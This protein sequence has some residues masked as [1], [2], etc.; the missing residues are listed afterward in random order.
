LKRATPRDQK[1]A[2]DRGQACTEQTVQPYPFERRPDRIQL[3]PEQ[4]DQRCQT[5]QD[6]DSPDDKV[7]A[8]IE[9]D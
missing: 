2:A 5:E 8:A 6:G 3:R 1:R 4:G 9:P 7:T